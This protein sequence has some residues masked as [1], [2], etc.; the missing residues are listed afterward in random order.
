MTALFILAFFVVGL[1]VLFV[2]YVAFSLNRDI[3]LFKTAPITIDGPVVLF[4]AHHRAI[5][6]LER[7]GF[8]IAHQGTFNMEG[9]APKP[10]V[11]LVDQAGTTVA[12]VTNLVLTPDTA[13]MSL[14]TSL[15]DGNGWL[16][17][18]T[19]SGLLP[20]DH[21]LLQVFPEADPATLLANHQQALGFLEREAVRIDRVPP[22]RAVDH[23]LASLRFSGT[24][25]PPLVQTIIGV[26]R[27][28]FVGAC[29]CCGSM[30][31]R[32]DLDGHLRAIRNH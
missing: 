5:A 3:R 20:G 11:L 17:T 26:L 8:G 31:N 32:P 13:A 16:S 15:E 1:F 10:V 6:A 19:V 23:Y 7:L 28:Q 25:H 4:D 2:V 22:G 9:Q 14:M 21:Q 29:P 27:M 24:D 30:L 18:Q 12:E